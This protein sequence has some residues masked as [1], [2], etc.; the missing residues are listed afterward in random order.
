[1]TLAAHVTNYI[2]IGILIVCFANQV[3]YFF[4]PYFKKE[5]EHSPGREHSFAVLV[6]ARNEQNVIGQL[7]ES[8]QLQDYPGDMVDIYVV[9]DNCDDDTAKE[10]AKKGAFVYERFNRQEVGKGY[11]LNFLLEHMKKD[12]R[13]ERYDGFF[14]FDADNLLDKN[15][16]KEMNRTF[17]D[18]YRVITSYR[19]TKNF[20]TNWLT[21]G[22]GLWFMHEAQ[23]LNRA[24]MLLHTSCAVSGTGFFFSR[25]ILEELGG[26]KFFLLTED[27]E[28]TIYQMLKGERIGYCKDAVFYDEQ[29]D[30]F[31][32]S[33][34][35][36][37]R[38][39]KGY[40][41]VFRAYGGQIAKAIFKKRNFSCFDMTMSIWPAFFLT[42]FSLVTDA[43]LI[44][45]GLALDRDIDFVLYNTVMNVVRTY[46]MAAL[47][48]LYTLITEWKNIYA[49]TG[50]KLLSIVT[51]PI[52]MFTFIPIAF[53]ALVKKVEWKPIEHHCAVHVDHFRETPEESGKT[54]IR[55]PKG[56]IR[57]ERAYENFTGRR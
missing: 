34:N 21:S 10:A 22:Y 5:K 9:A 23:W 44:I 3:I 41:Q 15:Y 2:M 24:R 11:A 45:A 1:M 35:Q 25:E 17:C 26:W 6:A 57:R 52:F 33:W 29:P 48:G 13:W 47:L 8:I 56:T 38:W 27:I 36:R 46:I 37:A 4:V 18:G 31:I 32:P 39:V 49:G 54:R 51:F 16:I 12:G 42:A 7:I 28:F 30:K 55:S 40:Q 50:K 20:G 43:V 19:N 14:V 53:V